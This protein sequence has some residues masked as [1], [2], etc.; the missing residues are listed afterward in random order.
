MAG[1]RDCINNA[2]SENSAAT[3]QRVAN[4][5]T[6]TDERKGKVHDNFIITKEWKRRDV[7]WA[8]VAPIGAPCHVSTLSLLCVVKFFV[9]DY[10]TFMHLPLFSLISN[11]SKLLNSIS[12]KYSPYSGK[13]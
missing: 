8:R 6:N 11:L 9:M 5:C 13:F 4:I 2:N 3:A 1:A 10:K 7:A 12:E